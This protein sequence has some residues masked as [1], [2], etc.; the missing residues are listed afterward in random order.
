MN[1]NQKK[2][3][4]RIIDDCGWTHIV[5]SDWLSLTA[6]DIEMLVPHVRSATEITEKEDTA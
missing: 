3:R 4:F 2:R 5:E 1:E 6:A